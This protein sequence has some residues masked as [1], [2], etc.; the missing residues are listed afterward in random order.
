MEKKENNDSVRPSFVKTSIQSPRTVVADEIE[1]RI[2]TFKFSE[3]FP[4][5]F[6]LAKPNKKG[7]KRCFMFSIKILRLCFDSHSQLYQTTGI[8]F[9]E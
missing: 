6:F 8:I 4:L 7:K 5:H 3:N 2:L 1:L 9:Q